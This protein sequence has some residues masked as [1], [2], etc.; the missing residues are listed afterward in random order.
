MPRLQLVVVAVLLVLVV[1]PA[2]RASDHVVVGTALT[3]RH[4]RS[5]RGMVSLTLR[6]AS[7]PV[8][9]PGGGTDPSLGS[10]VVTLFGRQSTE[11]FSFVAE[12]GAGG[13]TWRVHT[14]PQ[15]VRYSYSDPGARASATR[16]RTAQLGSGAGW[17]ARTMAAG[18]A[19]V[20]PETAVA[21]RI[22]WGTERA[23]A[24]FDG[25]AVRTSKQGTFVAKDAPPATIADCDDATLFGTTSFDC[26]GLAP[27]CDG[28]CPLGSTCDASGPSDPTCTCVFHEGCP[29]GCPNGWICAYPEGPTPTCVPP[30]CFSGN[31]CGGTCD[32]PTA[33]CTSFDNLCFCLTPCQG[34]DPYPTCGGSCPDPMTTCQAGAGGCFCT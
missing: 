12:P 14:T 22:D 9:A 21:V 18:L 2:S 34:G 29:G 31:G 20:V 11:R 7:I 8:G 24:L 3:I 1:A 19:L 23:C 16:I 30:F 28:D 5:G 15:G 27:A 6:D 17:S 33:Q 4:S 10:T 13:G 32:D 25:A 26:G